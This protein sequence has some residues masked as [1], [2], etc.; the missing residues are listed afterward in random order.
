L[1]DDLDRSIAALHWLF[2]PL[3][4]C[5]LF[6]FFACFPLLP[7]H[8]TMQAFSRQSR[9]AGA[10]LRQL[11]QRSYSSATSPYAATIKNLRINGDTKVLFQGFT[12]KQ[13]T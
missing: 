4:F 13:G 8:S 3:L 12:G 7:T 9:P 1:N 10:L 2:A 11:A 5:S 6:F